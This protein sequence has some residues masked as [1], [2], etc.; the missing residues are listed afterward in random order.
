MQELRHFARRAID[1]PFKPHGRDYEGWDCWG[2]VM[3]A[4]RDVLGVTIPDYT[5]DYRTLKDF[6][7]LQELFT[8]RE[9]VDRWRTVDTPEVMDLVCINRRGVPIHVG[10]LLEGGRV[11]H[12]EHGVGTIHEPTRD[13]NIEGYYR[14]VS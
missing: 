11:L 12:S 4:Y 14:P 8:D 1:I 2:L 13:L 7:R 10:L 5:D 6:V 9:D 3:V